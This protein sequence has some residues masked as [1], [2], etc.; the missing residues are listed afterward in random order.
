[1]EPITVAITCISLAQTMG[2]FGSSAGVPSTASMLEQ[3]FRLLTVVAKVINSVYESLTALRSDVAQLKRLTSEVPDNVVVRLLSVE[4]AGCLKTYQEEVDEY[5]IQRRRFGVAAGEKY[6]AQ[7]RALS[8]RMRDLRNKAFAAD[9]AVAIPSA[10]A[11]MMAEYHCLVLASASIARR[12]I[13]LRESQRW[14]GGWIDPKKRRLQSLLEAADLDLEAMQRRRTANRP[15]FSL[16]AASDYE[17]PTTFDQN[18]LSFGVIVPSVI[19]VEE[20]FELASLHGVASSL[21]SSGAPIPGQFWAVS[22]YTV[23]L[24]KRKIRVPYS[25]SADSDYN[26]Q[27]NEWIARLIRSEEDWP[28]LKD[29]RDK[30]GVDVFLR[31]F[32]LEKERENV[33]FETLRSQVL[34]HASY[35]IVA[36]QATDFCKRQRAALSRPTDSGS[37]GNSNL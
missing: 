1:M 24:E 29:A 33:E 21:E 17:Q 14:F 25:L 16:L 10:S 13:L 7:F 4:L 11:L 34:A 2:L 26:A 28:A 12:E 23:I 35:Y 36:S 3:Q 22:N 32:L 31:S 18:L 30:N 9:A 15:R 27:Y 19:D 5:D 20:P 37:V 6:E 8:D